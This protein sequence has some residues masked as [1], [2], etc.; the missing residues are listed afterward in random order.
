MVCWTPLNRGHH[1]FSG[2]C[3]VAAI[4]SEASVLGNM[5]GSP[6]TLEIPRRSV[7]N[8]EN[9]ICKGRNNKRTVSGDEKSS[10]RKIKLIFKEEG[11][12]ADIERQTRNRPMDNNKKKAKN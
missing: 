12:F 6:G 4:Y 11:G 10:R 7:R 1:R 9:Q 2:F 5:A 8:A 3:R